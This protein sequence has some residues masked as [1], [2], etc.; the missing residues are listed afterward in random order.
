MQLKS[1]IENGIKKYNI[2]W[3][4]APSTRT[5]NELN[6]FS[7]TTRQPIGTIEKNKDEVIYKFKEIDSKNAMGILTSTDNDE[8]EVSSTSLSDIQNLLEAAA[9][10][11]KEITLDDGTKQHVK[12]LM[13]A[14]PALATQYPDIEEK[15]NSEAKR[16]LR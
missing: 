11:K 9:K 10:T 7:K 15:V 14:D 4:I 6:V 13:Q 16:R 1:K 3:K 12:D 5:N 8:L 2:D